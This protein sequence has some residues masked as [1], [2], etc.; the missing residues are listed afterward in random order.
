[1]KRIIQIGFLILAITLLAS[2]CM[3]CNQKDDEKTFN[4]T[5][6]AFQ[7]YAKEQVYQK[8]ARI[9]LKAELINDSDN[10]HRYYGIYS[11]FNASS[12]LYCV[13]DGEEYHIPYEDLVFTDDAPSTKLVDAHQSSTRTYYF[14]IPEDAPS[15]EYH[16]RLSYKTATET[17][18]NIFTLSE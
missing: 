9:E 7:Y 1:M 8:G 10:R 18:Y 15:G 13:V 16:L 14:N 5:D 3:G 11:D 4:E 2:L 17:F 6:F 12:T